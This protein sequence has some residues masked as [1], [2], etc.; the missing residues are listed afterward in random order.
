MQVEDD[1]GSDHHCNGGQ[2]R[3][4]QLLNVFIVVSQDHV[5]PK[6]T[7]LCLMGRK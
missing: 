7:I 5:T 2:V 4:Y 1:G 6:E 3:N